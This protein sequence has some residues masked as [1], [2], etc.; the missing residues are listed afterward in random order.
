MII[1][2]FVYQ[3]EQMLFLLHGTI[4]LGKTVVGGSTTTKKMLFNHVMNSED[5]NQVC[6]H[7]P[8]VLLGHKEGVKTAIKQSESPFILVVY[9]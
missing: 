5:G 2:M 4:T 7:S 8:V 3:L 6:N 9:D 1:C